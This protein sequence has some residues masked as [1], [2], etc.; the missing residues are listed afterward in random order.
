MSKATWTGS[1][2]E[3]LTVG[4]GFVLADVDTS[5][6]P[7]IVA[8]K[9]DG[10]R[11]LADSA[12]ELADQQERL[13]ADSRM[14]GTR[15][16]LLVIQA[17]DTAGKGGIVQHVVGGIS[18][19]GVRAYGFKKPTPEELEHDF[20]WRIRKQ[21][22]GAGI[23]GVFDRSHYE[24]VLVAR[25]RKLA[26]PEVIEQRYRLIN[27]FEAELVASGTTI[28]KV[29]L[30]LGF[31]EQKARLAA[32]LDD[33]T[34]HWKYNP[35][36]LD[37]RAFWPQYQEAYQLALEKTST[38]DAPWH[39]VPADRKWYARIA[40]QRLLLDALRGLKLE[41]PVADYDVDAEKARLAAS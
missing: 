6:T 41:W 25:V 38:P 15:S 14:G 18:P 29:M 26:E 19:E 11:I 27:D 28:V 34:K 39:V 1:P 13:F 4:P 37:E 3:L 31:D 40:V 5:S 30:H 10:E 9:K 7:G 22:P 2:T 21:L 16:L 36:D 8:S 20:L 17:M 23:V 12:A 35:G 24:D 33:P 32:R